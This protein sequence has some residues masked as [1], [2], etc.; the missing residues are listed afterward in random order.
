MKRITGYLASFSGLVFLLQT[1]AFAVLPEGVF[2]YQVGLTQTEAYELATKSASEEDRG[3]WEDKDF[4]VNHEVLSL[5]MSYGVAPATELLWGLVHKTVKNSGALEPGAKDV[6]VSGIAEV[7][8]G[9]KRHLYSAG[10]F[11][12]EG[13]FVYK[14]PG[15]DYNRNALVTLG[16]GTTAYDLTLH[17]SL[18]VADLFATLDLTKS[19]RPGKAHDQSKILLSFYYTI[20]QMIGTG[21]YYGTVR[22]DDGI[23]IGSDEWNSKV[24][25]NETGDFGKPFALLNE[26]YDYLGLTAYY[27]MGT[28]SFGFS[29]TAKQEGNAK[30]T[31]LNNST[32]LW[33]SNS[34]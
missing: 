6:T 8:A 9:V 23:D 10:L 7:S 17:T 28:Y 3:G 32:S 24:G 27:I 2:N 29:Y 14:A 26:S 33:F 13:S 31:D 20:M 11:G 1:N 25:V 34:I 19:F 22:T 18:A 16:N 4:K 30:N 12:F 21:L 15:S 5:K